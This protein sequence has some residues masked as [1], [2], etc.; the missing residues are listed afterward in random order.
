MPSAIIALAVVLGAIIIAAAIM[1]ANRHTLELAREG[2]SAWQLNRLT[3][4]LRYCGINSR[5]R[6]RGC[7]V[8][9]TDK[10][11]KY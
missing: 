2:A 8:V 9:P 5:T 4:T 7:F 3:G 1:M 10:V 6:E 11:V